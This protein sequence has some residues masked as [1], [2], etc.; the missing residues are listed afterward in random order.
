MQRNSI[1]PSRSEN[2]FSFSRSLEVS[3]LSASNEATRKI[4][5]A[6]DDT[7]NRS[8]AASLL[9]VLFIGIPPSDATG[10]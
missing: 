2:V 9:E 10:V 7:T 4:D 5:A 8:D 1:P 3:A 6:S